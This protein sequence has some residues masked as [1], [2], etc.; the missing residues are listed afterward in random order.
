LI[1]S[2]LTLTV[3]PLLA[4]YWLLNEVLHSAIGLVVVP[5]NQQ[6]LQHYRDD[7][8]TLRKLDPEHEKKYKNRF[9]Q[10]SDE[11]LIYQKPE[12][13]QRVLRGTFLT[14]YLVLFIAVL[15]FAVVAAIWLSQKVAHSYK[16]LTAKDIQKAEKIY[17]LIYFDEWQAIASKLAHEINNPLTPIEMMVSNLSRVYS[18]T[19]AEVFKENLNDTQAMVS[20]EVKKLK[21]MVNHFSRFS[22]LPEPRLKKCNM[23]DYCTGFIRQYQHAWPKVELTV[24][25]NACAPN[26]LVDIDYLLFNQCLI[27]MINNAVQANKTQSKINVS[28]TITIENDSEVSLVV[29]NDGAV[30]EAADI[31][32]IFQMY[33]SS[34]RDE[35]NMGLGLAIVKKIILDHGG[36]IVCV[37]LLTGAAFKITLPLSVHDQEHPENI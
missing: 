21:D 25:A 11:L 13:L 27:N 28:L 20:E 30:I 34:K 10:V 2:I 33:Y 23:L 14:Y 24:K 7:L 37:P 26:A 9:L 36:D 32:T 18:A 15:I 35:E 8:K 17:E 3:I 22:K 16:R 4:S 12:L 29:H 31:K 6:L 19:S 5:E 1:G